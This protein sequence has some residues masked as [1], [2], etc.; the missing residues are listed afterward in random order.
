MEYNLSDIELIKLDHK[1]MRKFDIYLQ[2]EGYKGVKTIQGDLTKSEE[3]PGDSSIR[4]L[5]YKDGSYAA[6][7]DI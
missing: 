1:F 2:G 6:I 5:Q 4:I 3:S 7:L